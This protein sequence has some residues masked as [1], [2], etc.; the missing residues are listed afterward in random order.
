MTT[1]LNLC[2]KNRIMT[3]KAKKYSSFWYEVDTA[4]DRK[5]LKLKLKKYYK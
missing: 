2:I 5:L 1:F 4:S 3:L